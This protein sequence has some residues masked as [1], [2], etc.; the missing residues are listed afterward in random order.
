M[1][2][3]TLDWEKYT[4]TAIQANIEG[5]VLLCNRD[6]ALPLAKGSKAAVFGRMQNHYYKS[7]TGS[8]GMVNVTRVIGILDALSECE[9][10]VLNKKLIEVYAEWEQTH[11]FDNGIGWGN[12]PWSQE[13]MPLTDELVEA[14]AAESNIALAIIARTAG[15]DKDSKYEPGSYLLTET[16]EDMLARIR[17]AFDKVIVLLNVGNV[18]DMSFVDKYSPDAVLYIWQGGMTGG[19]AVAQVLTGA[20]YPSGKLTDTVAYAIE[21][22]PS[23]S[24]FGDLVRNFYVEDI[25]VGYRYFETVA[26]DKVRYPFG[27]GLSYTDFE[28][29]TTAY[30]KEN[31][32]ILLEVKVTNTGNS[33]GKEVVQV[34]YQAPQGVLGR[35]LKSLIAFAKTKELQPSQT[36]TLTFTINIDDMA[37]YDDSGI[38]SHKSCYV[39]EA[40]E[41]K[42]YVGNN[43]RD[44]QEAGTFNITQTIVT[45][46]LTEAM[47]PVMEY[48]R[49]K[50]VSGADGKISMSLEDVPTA[51]ID[52]MDRRRAELPEEL[53]YTGDKGIK[54]YDVKQ[55]KASLE[56]FIAQ[57]SDVDLSCIIKGEGMGSPKVT[58]GTASAFGGVTDSLKAFGIPCGCC[59]D[60]PSGIR[61]DNGTKA[62]SLPN[63]TLLACSFN[64]DL[65]EEL[66]TYTGIELVKN[67]IETLLGPGINIHRHPLNGRNFEYFSE[68][69]LLTG[70]MAAAMIRGLNKSGVTGTMKHFCANNQETKRNE[71]D[72]VVSERA[73]R[74]IYLKGYEIA[75]KEGNAISVMTSYNA[76]NGIWAAGNYDLN[77]QIL[78]KE[79]GY[80]GIV[81]TDWWA[82]INEKGKPADRTN[83]A[84]MARAQNDLYMV[85][86]DAANHNDNTLRAL[87]E[88]TLTRAELQRN[89]MNICRFLMNTHALDRMN[90]I[91]SI[92]ELIYAPSEEEEQSNSEILF[93]TIENEV[94][95]PLEDIDTSKGSDYAF[96]LDTKKAALFKMDIIGKS[97]SGELAQIPM[98]I[99]SGGI[100]AAVI[101]W[102]GTEGKWV[103]KT[104]KLYLNSGYNT[105]K[106]HFGQSG[107]ILKSISFTIEQ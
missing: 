91:N 67:K 45:K 92:V 18:I 26:P 30:K 57:L 33:K 60:G 23:H 76:I 35:P 73:L 25:Y 2:Q 21:D 29:Q 59:A 105:L 8:G 47:A 6:N 65:V 101:T 19:A 7:G 46:S 78:R 16:E 48:K 99:Y 5:T 51:T 32:Y 68:D 43:V 100:T 86:P 27:Y 44:T 79:W 39:L 66:Y 52:P 69:P 84:A 72:S 64:E 58:P 56:E 11:P 38:S 104:E 13:E 40:G 85:C 88:G 55:G 83:L 4:K 96:A 41:Y 71:N 31:D 94:E 36:Q 28:I 62:F 14:V 15:E 53:T 106:L 97:E 49:M 10:I 17:K 1:F 90:G 3:K 37:A 75:V 77:T 87:E 82:H 103:T 12:E 81:M 107:L 89:A 102:N 24:D 74:E 70:K 20:A 63:G 42:L 54:L 22:Y 93:Y 98:T 34:Y 80:T 9:D 50:P 61:M 95:I